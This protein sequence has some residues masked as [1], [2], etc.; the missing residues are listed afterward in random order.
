MRAIKRWEDPKW[1]NRSGFP[2]LVMVNPPIVRLYR[3]SLEGMK[4][5]MSPD[6]HSSEIQNVPGFL[7][8]E[9]VSAESYLITPRVAARAPAP[10]PRVRRRPHPAHNPP[11]FRN[12]P[13]RAPL[14]QP[15]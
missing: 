5:Q 9:E 7:A 10:G 15:R 6:R 2:N 13:Q 3:A 12:P 14:D 1:S 11:R 4:V 8:P